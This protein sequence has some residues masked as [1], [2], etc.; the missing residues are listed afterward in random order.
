M[1]AP[2][3]KPGYAGPGDPSASADD[4]QVVITPASTADLPAIFRL[5]HEV[6][7]LELGQHPPNDDGTLS[8]G[9]DG[10]NQ[11]LMARSGTTLEGFVS[12]TP[13]EAGRWS[14]DKY[15]D[16]AQLPFATDDTVFEVR[17]LTVRPGR[18][19][20]RVAHRLMAAALREVR[21]AGGTRIVG[22]GRDDLMD[23]YRS[24]GLGPLGIPITSGAVRFEAMTATVAELVAHAQMVGIPEFDDGASDAAT[25]PSRTDDS[26][27]HGGAFFGAIGEDFADLDRR[28]EVINADV[29]DAWF[30]PAPGVVTALTDH[31]PWLLSTSPPTDGRGLVDA[32]AAVRGLD[33]AAVL[34]G[35]GSSALIYL[36]FGRW[37]SP[38]SRVLLPDPTYGEYA[39]VLEHVIGCRVD[40]FPLHRGDGY[41]LD[42][43]RLVAA[44]ADHDLLVLVNP[45]SPTGQYVPGDELADAL[46]RLAPTT[47]VW[48]DETYVDHPAGS[49][50]LERFA[51]ASDSVT[52]V[53]SMS[54]A[55]AL[56]G[57][58]V[59]YLAGPPAQLAALRRW[60]P[61]W[62][63]SLPAQVAAV[64][65][66][67]DP[68]Y[69]QA[70]WHE[71]STLRVDLER[72][73]RLLGLAVVPGTAN[74]VLA[75]LPDDGPD[76]ATVVRRCAAAGVFLRD[77]G[78]MGT[79]LGDRALR[80]AVKDGP[81][82]DRML[83]VLS[84]ALAPTGGTSSAR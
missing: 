55:Y 46:G 67:A 15:L 42:P 11:Y 62:A 34:V 49:R 56:S 43:H 81:S 64:R 58:R 18:R 1:S 33:P 45:N 61:P 21:R 69:Y 5:R 23:L 60:T 29:L 76:A 52:V 74:F 41:R 20:R 19:G 63:V 10:R 14:L 2:T 59:A 40:R 80:V 47:R 35:A 77:V 8:D 70:R 22:M 17:L 25:D 72:R 71:T 16:R 3:E 31:L 78:A 48:I 4:D 27:L 36:A 82:A 83:S 26:C 9:L 79:A 53:K 75:H 38:S 68:G 30:P 12:I 28:R 24:V 6:Y 44:A 54:K 37:L 32:I 73:L 84:R 51:A 7:A 65:A 39:H 66:L 13:P 57:A 50:S